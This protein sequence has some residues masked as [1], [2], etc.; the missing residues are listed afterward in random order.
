MSNGVYSPKVNP[1]LKDD[2]KNAWV[3]F[4][5]DEYHGRAAWPWVLF[6]LVSGTRDQV[7][8]GIDPAGN[9]A[10]GVA[11]E[12]VALFRIILEKAKASLA[13]LGPLATS[14]VYKFAPALSGESVWQAE[15]MGIS[16]PIQLWSAAP[17]HLLI[18]EALERIGRSR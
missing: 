6:A 16:T 1:A 13:K 9:L 7:L 5:P 2:W 4:G 18:D 11:P 3:K 15:P 17:A 8:D 10:N 12:D 14:E